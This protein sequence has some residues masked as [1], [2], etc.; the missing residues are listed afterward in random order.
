[1]QEV[2]S[3]HAAFLIFGLTQVAQSCFFFVY[4]FYSILFIAVALNTCCDI[5]VVENR[6]AVYECLFSLR[7]FCCQTFALACNES[8]V[9]LDLSTGTKTYTLLSTAVADECYVCK[10]RM[11]YW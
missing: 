9:E 7:S 10:N 4:S 6:C 8:V 5:Y 1:M 3:M 11:S 2:E